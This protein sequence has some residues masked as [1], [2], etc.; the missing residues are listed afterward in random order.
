MKLKITA[1][2]LLFLLGF[3]GIFY[4]CR[5]GRRTYPI[6]PPEEQTRAYLK[7][8]NTAASYQHPPGSGSHNPSL[9][10]KY[11]TYN[12]SAPIARNL[13][14][15]GGWPVQGYA[16]LIESGLDVDS[17]GVGQLFLSANLNLTWIELMKKQIMTLHGDKKHTAWIIDSAQ[18]LI[19]RQTFDDYKFS[20]TTAA[21][22]FFHANA[23]DM[24]RDLMLKFRSPRFTGDTC[25]FGIDSMFQNNCTFAAETPFYELR[26]DRVYDLFLMDRDSVTTLMSRTGF[27]LKPRS[28][29]ALFYYNTSSGGKDFQLIRIE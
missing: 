7:I 26:A 9:D 25:V 28:A 29:Y 4:A 13:R 10:F 16:N 11:E 5:Q 12:S 1:G 19:M 8:I 2:L 18:T 20:D 22:R 23:Y 27:E 15:P 6:V 17:N 3:S 14:F 21:I 24:Q